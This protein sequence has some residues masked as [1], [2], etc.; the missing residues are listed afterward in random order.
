MSNRTKNK[1][2]SSVYRRAALFQLS[3]NKFD[4]KETYSCLA[5]VEE[6][7]QQHRPSEYAEALYGDYFTPKGYS[8]YGSWWA[9]GED[10]R[11]YISNQNERCLA[12][13]FMSEIVKDL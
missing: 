11:G 13:L 1:R 7:R 5:V 10:E 6:A 9:R 2:L 12:L 8:R 4:N 3:A